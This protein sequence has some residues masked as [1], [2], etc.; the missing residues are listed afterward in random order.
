MPIKNL[1]PSEQTCSHLAMY[2]Q[3]FGEEEEEE[4]AKECI[5][6][7]QSPD[8]EG[9]RSRQGERGRHVSSESSELLSLAAIKGSSNCL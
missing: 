7:V 8:Q 5:K 6:A 1:L 4:G 2:R 9:H 3:A